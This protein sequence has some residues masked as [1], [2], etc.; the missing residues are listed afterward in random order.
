[1]G[2]YLLIH[3]VVLLP[4]LQIVDFSYSHTGSAHD[5]TAWVPFVVHHHENG[6]SPKVLTSTQHLTT[7]QH[8]LN[9]AYVH[10]VPGWDNQIKKCVDIMLMC[11]QW[12]NFSSQDHEELKTSWTWNTS[13]WRNQQFKFDD[14]VGKQPYVYRRLSTISVDTMQH[15]KRWLIF[16]LQEKTH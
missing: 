7:G 4:N 10:Q 12:L 2:A 8:M 16:P 11:Y 9:H 1:M 3:W 6:S 14:H 15:P 5:S 13:P